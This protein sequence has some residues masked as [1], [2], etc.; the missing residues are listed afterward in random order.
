MTADNRSLR[1]IGV[2]AG[3][4]VGVSVGV[5][6]LGYSALKG[7]AWLDRRRFGINGDLEAQVKADLAEPPDVEHRTI[8]TFDGGEIHYI[9]RESR[10]HAVA[11]NPKT[12]SSSRPETKEPTTIVLLHGIT[13][14]AA[15]WNHQLTDLS[16]EFRII[17]PDWRGHGASRAGRNGYGLELLA[18]DLITLLEAEQVTN[19]IV[20]G[21]SM[22]GMALLHA[23]IHY[24]EIVRTR[25][26]GAALCSTAAGQVASGP[27]RLPV[28]LGTA[29][30][31]RRPELAGRAAAEVP[32]DV[33]YAAVRLGFGKSPSPIA[34]EQCRQFLA[35]MSPTALSASMLSLLDHDLREPL[36]AITIPTLVLVGSKDIVT[37]PSQAEEMHTS[38]VGSE[39]VLFEGAGHLLMLERQVEFASALT[40]FARRVAQRLS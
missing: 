38:I 15:V 35:R 1:R 2:G 4:G 11:G 34:V 23:L 21:H 36:V 37:P 12:Q 30:A 6:S 7:I 16:D 8:P 32:G 28:H 24:P 3:V 14:G 31:K 10:T 25:I 13:L 39:L 29:F 5:M 33:G 27:L 20:V 17:A 26:A 22:G 18:R 9:V 40:T 19:A